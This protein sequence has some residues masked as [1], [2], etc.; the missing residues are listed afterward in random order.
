MQRLVLSIALKELEKVA[1]RSACAIQTRLEH[2][3]KNLDNVVENTTA[4]ES[5]YVTQI[6]LKKWLLTPTTRFWPRL[7]R[8]CW[9]RLTRLTRVYYPY[10][11]N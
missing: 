2:T 10:L 1:Q 11:A 7:D 9:L 4:N 3:I 6:W 5:L 8:L